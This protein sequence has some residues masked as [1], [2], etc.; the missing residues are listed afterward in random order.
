MQRHGTWQIFITLSRL[1]NI[2]IGL[3]FQRIIPRP[4]QA[5]NIP[6]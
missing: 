6:K 4:Y 1:V 3:K 5:G 2:L